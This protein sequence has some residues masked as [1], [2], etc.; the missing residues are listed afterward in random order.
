MTGLTR[1][2]ETAAF[3]KKHGYWAGECMP[4][5]RVA[6]VVP[7]IFTVDICIGDDPTEFAGIS[8]TYTYDRPT[9]AIAAW[10]AWREAGFDGE[11]V[12]WIRHQPSNRRRPAGDPTQ[13]KVRP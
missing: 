4:D 11:P 1:E 6:F 10:A 9:I 13:E 8:E 7:R 5:G 3:A 2:A 12:L